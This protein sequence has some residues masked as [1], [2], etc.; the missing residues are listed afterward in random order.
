[1]FDSF[2]SF[3]KGIALTGTYHR[4]ESSIGEIEYQ[5]DEHSWN[6]QK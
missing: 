6:L 1:M 2:L 4:W 3:Q 5:K